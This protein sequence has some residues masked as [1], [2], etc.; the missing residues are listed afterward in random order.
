MKIVP[1]ANAEAV[2][3]ALAARILARIGRNMP[4]LLLVSGGTCEDAAIGV[5]STVANSLVQERGK[6]KMLFT[7]G[8]TDERFG[9]TGHQDSIWKQLIDKGLD[10]SLCNMMPILADAHDKKDDL[11]EAVVRY[12]EFLSLA[13]RKRAE[14]KLIISTLLGIGEEGQIAGILP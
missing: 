6:L 8:L 10:P 5:L 2:V 3:S 1:N 12:N 9:E 14:G 4:V 11:D 13:I 7:F